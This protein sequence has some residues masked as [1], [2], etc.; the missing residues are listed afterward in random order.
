MSSKIS[1]LSAA[2]ALN[3]T[4]TF[5]LVQSS[6]TKKGLISALSTYL[7]GITAWLPF[8]KLTG[9]LSN[10]QVASLTGGGCPFVCFVLSGV[11]FNSANTDYSVTVALPTGF[12]RF[13]PNTCRIEGASA[14]L[15]TATCSLWTGAGATGTAIV[16]NNSAITVSTASEGTA[17]NSMALTIANPNILSFAAAT[18]TTLYFRVQTAQGSAATANVIIVL[19]A[20]P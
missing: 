12:T 1:A 18:V 16:A 13:M 8:S 2:S 6:T 19:S 15:T 3:G 11:N 17:N 4:E 7:A 10:S 5:P 20:L 9:A 14:S